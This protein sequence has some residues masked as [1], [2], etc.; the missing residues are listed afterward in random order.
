MKKFLSVFLCLSLL[1]TVFMLNSCGLMERFDQEV[2][3]EEK[4]DLVK[5]V[6]DNTGEFTEITLTYQEKQYL[7]HPLITVDHIDYS[8][9]VDVCESDIAIGW[10]GSRFGYAEVYY[11]NTTES[12]LFIYSWGG[13]VYIR[14]DYDAMSDTF[15]IEGTDLNMKIS[16]FMAED[17]IPAQNPV[18]HDD[19]K[20]VVLQSVTNNR[21][22]FCVRLYENQGEWYSFSNDRNPVDGFYATKGRYD[23]LL[24]ED[25]VNL[26]NENGIIQ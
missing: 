20:Y 6:V 21:L 2:F 3:S 18:A 19:T 4:K 8:D 9:S 13:G 1:F 5:S 17:E 14:E 23:T 12:P 10:E 24:Q 26:L 25:I 11:S 16:D 22:K 15:T 7:K